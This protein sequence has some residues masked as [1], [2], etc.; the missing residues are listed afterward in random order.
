[1][2]ERIISLFLSL[3]N[4]IST[5]K[6]TLFKYTQN[7]DL[8]LFDLV[9]IRVFFISIFHFPFTRFFLLKCFF[10][11]NTLK[12][13][14]EFFKKKKNW[15]CF[16]PSL[17]LMTFDIFFWLSNNV[18]W[19]LKFINV[20]CNCRNKSLID[21]FLIDDKS[22]YDIRHQLN[23]FYNWIENHQKR[24]EKNFK[25]TK[26]ELNKDEKILLKTIQDFFHFWSG[27]DHFWWKKFFVENNENVCALFVSFKASVS[28]CLCGI[29]WKFFSNKTEKSKCDD[30]NI[31]NNSCF[32][33]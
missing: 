9:K 13:S 4:D 17:T 5:F 19:T 22:N 7:V 23:R 30:I 21:A 27:D 29:T 20:N 16:F 26:L 1:M 3:S 12:I 2:I 31:N 15:K 25:L 11:K 14:V 18:Y 6:Y 28:C 10:E 33:I 8:C 32:H 24:K